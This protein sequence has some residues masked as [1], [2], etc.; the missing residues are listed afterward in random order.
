[1]LDEASCLEGLVPPVGG[2]IILLLARE[3][4]MSII[5]MPLPW[6]PIL[7]FPSAKFIG[8]SLAGACFGAV[9]ARGLL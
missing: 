6:L 5:S 8:F 9:V 2:L 4:G 1:M 7:A 3:F